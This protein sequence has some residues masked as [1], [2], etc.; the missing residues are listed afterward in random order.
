MRHTGKTYLMADPDLNT[1][2]VTDLRRIWLPR[3]PVE[4]VKV[5][6]F[7]SP[8]RRYEIVYRGATYR[9]GRIY[10]AKGPER[11]AA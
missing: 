8:R 11:V 3:V 1:M 10:D 9:T 4:L 6:H 5:H 2:A 7:A